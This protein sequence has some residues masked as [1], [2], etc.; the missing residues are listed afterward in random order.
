MGKRGIGQPN[1][2]GRTLGEV[3][4]PLPPV[5]EQRRI[6]AEIEKQFTQL[7]AGVTV[8]R[9]VQAKLKR[10]RA[11][12]LKAACEGRL[13]PTEAKLA[14]QEG[15]VYQSGKELLSFILAERLAQWAGRGNLEH[16]FQLNA[17]D[18]ALPEGWT[19]A[20]VDQLASPEP[21]SITDGPFGS[22]L[23]T[24]HY[25]SSGSEGCSFAEYWEKGSTS[26]KTRISLKATSSGLRNIAFSRG[27]IVIA[28]FGAN[29][30]R[31]CIIPERLGPA[32]VESR[33][34]PA[35]FASASLGRLYQLCVEF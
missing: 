7:E 17:P 21:N 10:Y 32:I 27:D 16:L 22:Y 8:L 3:T 26:T 28:A 14:R 31:S 1:V 33:L 24:E 2:N 34:Y 23:K 4:F 20:K 35:E 6:V 5:D 25:T 9:Q 15:R 19:W 11:A 29:P 18:H 13:V 12:V 30:P